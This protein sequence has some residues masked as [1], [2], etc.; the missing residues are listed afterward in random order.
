[1]AHTLGDWGE[2]RELV[3][4]V[5]TREAEKGKEPKFYR[6]RRLTAERQRFRAQGA[7]FSLESD[8]DGPDENGTFLVVFYD[9]ADGA[10]VH[11]YK[12]D[13]GKT[14]TAELKVNVGVSDGMP[15]RTAHAESINDGL[16]A[17]HQTHLA[18]LTKPLELSNSLLDRLDKRN[19][20][21]ESEIAKREPSALSEVLKAVGPTA[22]TD[23]LTL[24]KG[25]VSMRS[26]VPS[27]Q[28]EEIRRLKK[29][30]EALKAA[31]DKKQ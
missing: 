17:L 12:N 28:L 15:S 25:M 29:E 21:L 8:E 1:M 19:R 5:I 7:F 23:L 14:V 4:R 16:I 6:Y 18:L 30:N 2:L 13:A 22:L 26:D 3:S 11:K 31:I 9:S 20:E 10:S 27:Q 24:A